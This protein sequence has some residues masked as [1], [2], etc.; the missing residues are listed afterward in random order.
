[1]AKTLGR[2]PSRFLRPRTVALLAVANAQ[3]LD[4]TGPLEVF[5]SANRCLIEK[6]LRTVPAYRL[7]ILAERAGPVTMNNGLQLVATRAMRG[8]KEPIDSLLIAGGSGVREARQDEKLIRWIGQAARSARRVASICS[9]A[10]LLA[11]TGLLDGRRATTHWEDC[12]RLA[13]EFPD[14]RVEPDRI[15]VRDGKF[16]S[17]GGV[18]AGMDLALHLVEQDW[19][20]AVAVEVARS[21][22][23]FLRR[24]GGQS[25]F[26]PHLAAE[27]G[28]EAIRRAQRHILD[29]PE[30]DLSVP[31][32]AAV[33]GMSPRN[34]ARAFLADTGTTPAKF[35]EQARIDAARLRLEQSDAAIESIARGCGFGAPE[36]M[37]RA[38]H[39]HLSIDPSSYRKTFSSTLETRHDRASAQL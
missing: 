20:R 21:L 18:T 34:F 22:V 38:F 27:S 30:A 4:V 3:I 5:G 16:Y 15:F 10:F 32:L 7:H 9:G 8:R 23:L 12:A 36:R 33:A 14:I 24:P 39:R 25:Q 29:H 35:V 11:A 31:A 1:M 13:R 19:G 2:S 28:R 26:S 37:R 17:S 6:G